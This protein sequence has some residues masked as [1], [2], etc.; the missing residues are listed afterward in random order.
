ML[1]DV[2]ELTDVAGP[3]EGHQPRLRV[4]FDHG[5]CAI[6]A[7]AHPAQEEFRKR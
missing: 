6:Q 2:L 7:L 5:E 1:N 4:G 3:A